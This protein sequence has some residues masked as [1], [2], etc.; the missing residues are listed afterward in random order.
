MQSLRS[1]LLPILLLGVVWLM[2]SPYCR[3]ATAVSLPA[4]LSALQESLPEFTAPS[5]NGTTM[6]STELQ[7]KVVVLRFWASW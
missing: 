6:H 3:A 7:G 2:T 5:V 4:G 1:R